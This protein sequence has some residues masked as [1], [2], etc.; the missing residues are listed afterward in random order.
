[1]TSVDDVWAQIKEKAW[2]YARDGVSPSDRETRHLVAQL[3]HAAR[4][5]PKPPNEVIEF[6]ARELREMAAALATV[7]ERSNLSRD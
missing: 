3:L 1:M 5:D 4:V 7:P 2:Q 6:Y